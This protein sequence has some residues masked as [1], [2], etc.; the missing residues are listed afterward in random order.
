[1]TPARHFVPFACVERGGIAESYHF[2]VAVLADSAG[3]V[4]A[5]W[6]DPDFVT[7]PRSAL[8]PFQAVDLIESGAFDAFGLSGEQ[9]ALACASHTGEHF[10]TDRVAAWLGQLGCD[11]TCLA[12]GPAL[13]GRI[14]ALHAHL[15]AGLPAS[16]VLYNC[17]G[18]HCGFLTNARHLGLPRVGYDAPDHA[19]QV[20]YRKVLSRFLGRKADD[21]PWSRDDCV[22][23]A[24]A[25]PTRDM[26]AALARFTEEA[27]SGPD[28]AAARI[29]TAM[30][31]HPL[32]LA[33]TG[34]L[35]QLLGEILGGRIV[36]KTGAEGYLAVFLPA[37]RLG[38]ALKVSDGNPRARDVALVAILSQIGV[39]STAEEAKLMQR[40]APPHLDSRHRA[41]GTIRPILPEATA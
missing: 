28:V 30:G 10:H 9:L 32:L 3:R 35:P 29:L 40:L 20:R 37:E 18:K 38:L 33:G 13:P 1:M 11:E 14:D 34:A 27:A 7:F 41:V 8:K 26:A 24:P 12:C 31:L 23:P 39:I 19:L 6:G 25:M 2:G 16:P 15:R 5:A 17:S 21:L 22:L 4:R 36:A